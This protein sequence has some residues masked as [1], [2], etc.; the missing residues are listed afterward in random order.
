MLCSNK[1]LLWNIAANHYAIVYINRMKGIQYS[2]H[3]SI[4]SNGVSDAIYRSQ[5]HTTSKENV[6]V[7]QGSKISNIDTKVDALG[8]SSYDTKFRSTWNWS[9]RIKKQQK[10]WKILFVASWVRGLCWCIYDQMDRVQFLCA[11]VLFFCFNF[12]SIKENI[13][14]SSLDFNRIS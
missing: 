12:D 11:R 10:V 8:F 6:E 4:I 5:H 2:H 9:I 13:N 14:G 7:D 1:I 3:N